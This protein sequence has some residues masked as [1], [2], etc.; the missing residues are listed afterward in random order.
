[1]GF[2]TCSAGRTIPK[3]F[4]KCF[5]YQLTHKIKYVNTICIYFQVYFQVLINKGHINRNKK[6]NVNT[7][8]YFFTT[9]S[10]ISFLFFKSLFKLFIN[11]GDIKRN[12]KKIWTQFWNLL[13]QQNRVLLPEHHSSLSTLLSLSSF[14]SWSSLYLL[15]L[16]VPFFFSNM[17]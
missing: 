12:I 9:H 8:H 7:I 6:N 10:F 5:K 11:K 3:I 16:S 2:K 15:I 1:M 4:F 14:N 17:K 13:F